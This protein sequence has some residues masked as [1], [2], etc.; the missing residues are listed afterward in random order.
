MDKI[1]KSQDKPASIK[2]YLELLWINLKTHVDRA[3]EF[4]KVVRRYYLK[5][6]SFCKQDLALLLLYT[7]NSPFT[8]SKKFLLS[9]GEKEVYT[10]GETDLTTLE[11]IAKTCQ[12]S[13]TDTVYELGSGRGRG[14]FW[15]K[16]FIG[17]KVVGIEFIPEFVENAKL[18]KERFHVENVDFRLENM[19]ETDFSDATVIYLYGT[20]LDTASINQL[21]KKFSALPS[22]TKILTVSYPLTIYTSEPIFE[23][24]R[25]F[26]IEFPWGTTDLFFQ[27]KK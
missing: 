21:V 22:G 3:T 10:Y 25:C 14:C 24:M 16:A 20:C 8:I 26:Q 1:A 27:I 7:A 9:K 17:C 5:S 2:E 23:V 11:K 12:L 6:W 13:S 19:M 4:V 18:V 15:L